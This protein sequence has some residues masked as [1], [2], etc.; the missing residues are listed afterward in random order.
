M[1]PHSAVLCGMHKFF[2]YGYGYLLVVCFFMCFRLAST[3]EM[4]QGIR[5]V[6]P[7]LYDKHDFIIFF[8]SHLPFSDSCVRHNYIKLIFFRS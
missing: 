5:H 1:Y 4:Q 7:I 6:K 8:Y 2:I 3:L